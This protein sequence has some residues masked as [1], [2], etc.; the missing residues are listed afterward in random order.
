[1]SK[2]KGDKMF[3]VLIVEDH[4]SFREVLKDCL[5]D[6]SFSVALEDAASGREAME[7][8]DFSPPDLVL[9]DIRLPD[10][11]GLELT[12]K[13]KE[14]HPNTIVVI[15]TSYDSAEYR[16]LATAYGAKSFLCKSDTSKKDLLALIKSLWPH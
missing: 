16:E 2:I 3:K 6:E 10:I 1:M 5:S 15:L 12:K 11:S 9:M 7:K 8:V 13:I 4:R 14:N